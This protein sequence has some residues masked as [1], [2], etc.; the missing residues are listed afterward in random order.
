MNT[1]NTPSSQL[2][3]TF[4]KEGAKTTNIQYRHPRADS[5]KEELIEI[6][7]ESETGQTLINGADYHNIPI[8]VIRSIGESAYSPD[9]NTVYIAAGKAE[10]AT[11]KQVLELT[12]AL[13]E[14]EQ[15]LLGM[16]APD[17]TKDIMHYATIMHAK[18]L[19]AIVYMC[20]LVRDMELTNSSYFS[21]LLDE[22]KNLGHIKIYRAY[23]NEADSQK[24]FD[25]YADGS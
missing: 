22:I 18:K 4:E 5:I 9:A 16:S 11:P 21:V 10:K 6:M 1:E 12:G 20:K 14:A 8:H 19:D 2:Q 7:R 23:V 17:P 24:L 13:R 15:E 25:A 3:S